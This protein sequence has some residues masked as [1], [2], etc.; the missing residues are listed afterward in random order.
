MDASAREE[1]L[2]RALYK[3]MQEEHYDA[4]YRIVEDRAARGD[5]TGQ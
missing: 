4:A 1:L 2:V 3:V 5:G